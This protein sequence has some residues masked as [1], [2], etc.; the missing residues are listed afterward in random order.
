MRL[1]RILPET[2]E[3]VRSFWMVLHADLARV[4]RIR[5]VADFVAE[6]VRAETAIF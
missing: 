4:P 3:V 2:V 1:V 5:A 6:Q